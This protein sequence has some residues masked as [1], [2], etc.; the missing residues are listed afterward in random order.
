[1]PQLPTAPPRGFE[2]W[3]Q[4]LLDAAVL[5]ALSDTGLPRCLASEPELAAPLV[6]EIGA[7]LREQLLVLR[8]REAQLLRAREES[9]TYEAEGGEDFVRLSAE[10]ERAT[11]SY[12]RLRADAPER[13]AAWREK[14]RLA[15]E[16][17]AAC[18]RLQP[19]VEERLDQRLREHWAAHP[20]TQLP[21]SVFANASFG[22]AVS[23]L[24]RIHPAWWGRFFGRLQVLLSQGHPAQGELIAALPDLRARAVRKKFEA[25]IAEWRAAH[26]DRWG[27]Y[28]RDNYRML[29]PRAQKKARDTAA[30]FERY[31]AGFLDD[32]AR[33][34][35]LRERLAARLSRADPWQVPSPDEREAAHHG[36]N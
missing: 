15:A 9:P 2:S 1:M 8:V 26:A 25:V 4:V 12:Y 5:R 11:E 16:F 23:R 17:L 32:E 36:R 30:W 10:Q 14:E 24:A 31:A 3:T 29:V 33:R 35:E 34:R 7:S 28:G 21:D 20:M 6:A 13:E 22:A 19:L 27:W 18:A